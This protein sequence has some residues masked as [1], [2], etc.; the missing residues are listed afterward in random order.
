M[1]NEK[2]G[3]A[4]HRLRYFKINETIGGV[5]QRDNL[6]YTSLSF[7]MKQGKEAGYSSKEICAAVIRSIK[8]GSNLR[9]YLESLV[10]ISETAFIQTLRSHFKEKD[11]T[12]VF[13]KMSMVIAIILLAGKLF[14]FK[15]AREII[16]HC[17][18][19]VLF[20]VLPLRKNECEGNTKKTL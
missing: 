12:S 5:D 3:F 16:I 15:I 2:G 18:I 20:A 14:D 13:H 9:N 11:A 8:A 10:K 7:Q 19:I 6:S 1:T 17:V 4:I